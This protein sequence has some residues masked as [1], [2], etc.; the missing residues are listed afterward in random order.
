MP[1]YG[2][3]IKKNTRRRGCALIGTHLSGE[4]VVVVKNGG[5]ALLC[6]G[7]MLAN[8]VSEAVSETKF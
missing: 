8:V 2:F 6:L 7:S 4:F 1:Q 3:D 5:C